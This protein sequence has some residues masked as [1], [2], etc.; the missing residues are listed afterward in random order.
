MVF[1]EAYERLQSEK[2]LPRQQTTYYCVPLGA[3]HP[4][5]CPDCGARL[6]LGIEHGKFRYRCETPG[7]NGNS[8]ADINGKPEGI[9][10]DA[11]GRYKRWYLHSLIDPYWND[12]YGQYY[13]NSTIRGMIYSYFGLC[14]GIEDFHI[15]NLN[16]RQLDEAI[17]LAKG[18]FVQYM[19]WNGISRKEPIGDQIIQL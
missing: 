18:R 14:L 19:E 8:G 16:H 7:C 6:L 3:P 1:L 12:P 4:E 5:P 11:K 10:I 9:P 2:S 13:E 17:K 15:K